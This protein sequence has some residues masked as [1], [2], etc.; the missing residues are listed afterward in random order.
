MTRPRTYS[1]KPG[2]TK[3]CRA[4][5]KFK[6]TSEFAWAN[7]EMGY[8]QTNCI[9]CDSKKKSKNYRDGIKRIQDYLVTHPCVDCGETDPVVLEFDHVRG[10]KKFNLS[11]NAYAKSDKEI[12]EEIAKCEIRCRN[13]H[14]KRHHKEGYIGSGRPRTNTPSKKELEMKQYYPKQLKLFG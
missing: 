7:K 5:G 11:G 1:I 6:L 2:S 13:C 12:E 3:K 14:I 10:K 4:C 9:D 8:L